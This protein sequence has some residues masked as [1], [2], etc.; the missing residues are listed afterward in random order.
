MM[1]GC[2]AVR[3]SSRAGGARRRPPGSCATRVAQLAGRSGRTGSRRGS[4]GTGTARRSVSAVV[5]GQVEPSDIGDISP[6][7]SG[8]EEPFVVAAAGRRP[9]PSALR[10]WYTPTG[11]RG[12]RRSCKA[13]LIS[14]IQLLVM[15]DATIPLT[16]FPR[17]LR[18]EHVRE[19]PAIAD[20]GGGEATS[21]RRENRGAILRRQVV[22]HVIVDHDGSE[23]AGRA[24]RIPRRVDRY[25]LKPPRPARHPEPN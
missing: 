7:G 10:T 4:A 15:T 2:R 12:C 25:G 6:G 18:G 17:P 9:N 8:T 19:N 3:K 20:H 11:H 13:R 24:G 21:A 5:G 22:R 1:W 14:S 23:R 16:R